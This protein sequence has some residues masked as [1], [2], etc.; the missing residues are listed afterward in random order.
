M[1]QR[2][3]FFRG[4]EE[5]VQEEEIRGIDLDALIS[6]AR[7][8]WRAVAVCVA[9]SVVF[10]LCY[11]MTAVP[12]YTASTSV[13][14]DRS[15][16]QV[17]QQLSAI[18]SPLD[19]EASVLSQ[20]ELLKSE[21]IGLAAVDKLKLQDNPEFMAGGGNIFSVGMSLIHSGIGLLTGG[22]VENL[23][24][25]AEAKRQ[26][27]LQSLLASM[28]VSR[29]GRSY[30]LQIDI[31]ATS[32]DLAAKIAGAVAD[33]YLTDKLDAKY[34]ATRRAGTWLQERIEELRQ[35][36]LESDLAIQK[37]RAAN[38]L[39]VADNKLVSD[40][41]LTE[42]N[43]ALIV[44]R[45]DTARA[46][47]RYD[48]LQSII[49]SGQTDAIVTDALESSV[50]NTLREKYLD[51]SK[52]ESEISKRLG[53]DHIQAARL[54]QEMGEYNRL[55]FDELRR[56]S[57]SYQSELEVAQSRERQITEGVAS[58]TT[59]SVAASE[60]QVQLRELE[61]SAE[62]YKNLYQTFLQRYQEAVQQ[63]SFP[64]TEARIISYATPPAGPSEPRKF[65]VL[66]AGILLG[67][68]VG[69]GV[70]GFREFRDRFFRTG[71]QVR[72]VLSLEYLGSIPLVEPSKNK[73]SPGQPVKGQVFKR[74]QVSSYAIDH[75]LSSFAETLRSAKIAAD[76]SINK[77]NKI[78]GIVSALPGEGKSTIAVNLA[79]ILSKSAKTLLIDADLRN[80]GA[81][82]ALG[83]HA[84]EGLLEVL[85]ENKSP[86]SLLLSDSDSGLKFLPAV[87]KR[88]VPHSSELLAS[89][90][91]MKLL[92][93]AATEFDYVVLDLPPLGP[94]VDARAISPRVDGFVMVVEWGGASRK[95]VSD[96]LDA[97]PQI[98]NRC[99]GVVLNK[100]DSSKM[101]LYREYGSSE[102]YASRYTSYYQDNG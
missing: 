47:A 48:R 90:Q 54:R 55:M 33:A 46:Q 62:T 58:A 15:N 76:L 22:E 85:L 97:D 71:E 100:V 53:P 99:L 36:S 26:A 43:S 8:Q 35:R 7:R 83:Q 14:I 38:G 25:P 37:F 81:T 27:A 61:R 45:A 80:P 6:I 3:V 72:D 87:V 31:T 28:Q 18:G 65:L 40:Q 41:Q 1:N 51:A 4:K 92:S 21:T 17:V 23:Q 10:G 68:I 57:E 19:D 89:Q 50:I 79:Q 52:R 101:K 86:A 102:Y 29:V 84:D 32:P 42:L 77:Q 63:E 12:K 67:G 73:A 13:L 56:I 5:Q 93:Q 16:S 2:P 70:A 95:V 30:V 11:V 96:T 59:I 49:Q 91:M 9:V 69:V 88:R 60:T 82:R 24:D 64:V 75:P 78:I 74:N 66:A 34:D 39:V 20:V 98:V 94:V 44:A